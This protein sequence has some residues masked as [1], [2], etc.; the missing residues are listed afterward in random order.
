MGDWVLG[1]TAVHAHLFFLDQDSSKFHPLLSADEQVRAAKFYFDRDRNR[2]IVARGTLRTLI[3][4]YEQI[5]PEKVVFEYNEY[6][7][8]SLCGNSDL[9]FNLSHTQAVGVVGFT[10]GRLIGVDVEQVRELS[11]RAGVARISF[12]PNE[13][14]VFSQLPEAE[15]TAAFFRC[16]TRKEAFIKAIGE[17]L[18]HPLDS[19]DVDFLPKETGRFLRIEG[20]NVADWQM[21]ILGEWGKYTAVLVVASPSPLEVKKYGEW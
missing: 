10:R 13:F 15:K 18:S 6:G 1:E 4:H 12:S 16:W 7:K 2:Y 17:G 5:A 9:T 20:G 21:V 19:F 8:P 11:D 14:A 3:G